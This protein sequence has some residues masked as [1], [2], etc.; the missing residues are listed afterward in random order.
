MVEG[1]NCGSDPCSIYIVCTGRVYTWCVYSVQMNA[2][3]AHCSCF[4]STFQAY[5]PLRHGEGSGVLVHDR[6]GVPK[7]SRLHVSGGYKGM[8][9]LAVGSGLLAHSRTLAVRF[10]RSFLLFCTMFVYW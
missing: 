8:A 7:A 9:V 1:A 4:I 6:R 10:L 3:D 2:C 5:V